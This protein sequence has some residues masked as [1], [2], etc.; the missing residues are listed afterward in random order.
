MA[1]RANNQLRTKKPF[2]LPKGKMMMLATVSPLITK[3]RA[4]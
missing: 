2:V 4:Y 1:Y 3:R